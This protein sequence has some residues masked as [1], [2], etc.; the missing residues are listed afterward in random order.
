MLHVVGDKFVT[1]SNENP[2]VM[3]VS[4]LEKLLEK[5]AVHRPHAL[6]VGQGVSLERLGL[7]EERIQRSA[8]RSLVTIQ[9]A[10]IRDR[11]PGKYTHK[12]FNYNTIITTP[13]KDEAADLYRCH[14]VLDDDCAEMSDHVTGHHLQ[15]VVFFEASR[16]MLLAATERFWLEQI[17]RPYYFVLNEY[18]IT[19]HTFGF[20]L[21]TDI[22]MKVLA[23]RGDTRQSGSVFLDIKVE[24]FQVGVPITECVIKYAAFDKALLS[25]R[26]GLLSRMAL[27]KHS[28]SLSPINEVDA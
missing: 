28:P 26:E 4:N 6:I 14:L 13:Y 25:A 17:G 2:G 3:T 8:A 19:Y 27:V 12:H 11:C 16:Q 20:P 5:N 22:T 24:F 21:P 10:R 7:L 23:E 9:E 18:N 1:F 15:G